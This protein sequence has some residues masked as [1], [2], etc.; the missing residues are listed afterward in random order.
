MDEMSIETSF[1]S[2]DDVAPG[3]NVCNSTSANSSDEAEASGW[4]PNLSAWGKK[5]EGAIQDREY[6][7]K[8]S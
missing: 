7:A 4:A 3:K 8:N 6:F 5:V 1:G 2:K